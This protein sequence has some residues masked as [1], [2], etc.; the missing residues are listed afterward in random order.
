LDELL[1]A[2]GFGLDEL[3]D[4]L[5]LGLTEAAPDALLDESADVFF[6]APP[7]PPPPKEHFLDRKTSASKTR[8]RTISR[9]RQ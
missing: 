1:V 7:P 6:V 3:D 8:P 5:V 9:R 2:A 4:G